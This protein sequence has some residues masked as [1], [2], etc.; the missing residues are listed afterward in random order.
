MYIHRR[1]ITKNY[2]PSLWES[3][4]CF[5]QSLKALRCLGSGRSYSLPCSSTACQGFIRRR[6]ESTTKT[7]AATWRG[8]KGRRRDCTYGAG[9]EGIDIWSKYYSLWRRL[10]HWCVGYRWRRGRSAA[11][12]HWPTLGRLTRIHVNARLVLRTRKHRY[13]I[14]RLQEI[15]GET[16]D[17]VFGVSSVVFWV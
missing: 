9:W 14:G 1:W 8:G 13:F 7:R 5:Q 3:S 10:D 11:R 16:C 12:G 4:K 15:K 17:L 2:K 6:I